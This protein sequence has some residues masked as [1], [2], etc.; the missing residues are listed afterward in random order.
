MKNLLGKYSGT[1]RKLFGLIVAS[2]ILLA[3]VVYL[4]PPEADA[5]R[6]AA[7]EAPSGFSSRFGPGLWTEPGPGAS[8]AAESAALDT[9]APGGLATTAEQHLTVNKAL[10]DVI[11]Y[12]LLGGH[13]GERAEHV[14]SL[15]AHLKKNLP[16][17]AYAESVHIVQN[18]LAY[19]DAHDRLLERES[20]P[21]ITA[22]SKV[23]PPDVDR[24]AS[25]V[26]RRARLRQDL[27]GI[28]VA[29]IWFGE[30]ETGT[31]QDLANMR[32]RGERR[33]PTITAESNVLQKAGD[34]LLMMRAQGVSQE[35]QREHIASQFG[36]QA[37]ERFDAME[38]EEQAW[39]ARYA[40][41]RRAVEQILRQTG[42]DPTQRKRQIDVLQTQTFL[43]EPELLRARALDRR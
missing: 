13:P 7:S 43:T 15:L 5:P 33:S 35:A 19:L 9:V 20:A 4:R 6:S 12:F 36:P 17:A 22:D 42:M 29:Q 1:Q 23:S 2:G 31:Q 8:A 10:H 28:K 25:W 27:L 26:A 11:D 41:Y 14:A 30:D 16:G 32:Q 38:R 39:Q 34:T 24:I 37:A 21:A 18:Y 3:I 40:N